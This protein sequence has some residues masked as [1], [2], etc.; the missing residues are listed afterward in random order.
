MENGM[1]SGLMGFGY[2][3]GGAR[4]DGKRLDEED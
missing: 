4:V 2:Y 1:R 3:I